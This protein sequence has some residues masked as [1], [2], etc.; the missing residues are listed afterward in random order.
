MAVSKKFLQGAKTVGKAL[1]QENR[2]D[3]YGGLSAL[4]I[5][6]Q[7][8]TGGAGLIIGGVTAFN[9]AK[10]GLKGH[11]RTKLGRITYADGPARMTSSYTSGAVKAMKRA[12][13]GNYAIFSDMA[14]EVVTNDSIA[15]RIDNYGVTPELVSAL[16]N[17]G[18]R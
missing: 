3:D 17:M 5:R 7:V 14:K 16:Y 2:V 8:N 18:G 13:G 1:T 15:G 12:S 4:L 10:E 9:F 11:N 6:R